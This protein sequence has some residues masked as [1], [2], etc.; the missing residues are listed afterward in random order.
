M[1][2]LVVYFSKFGNTKQ[3]A[4][5]I[6][7]TLQSADSVRVMSAEQLAT[8]GFAGADLVV[9]GTPTHK[10]NLPQTV[11]PV[12]YSLPKCILKDVPV[13]VHGLAAGVTMPMMTRAMQPATAGASSENSTGGGPMMMGVLTGHMV[14]GLVVALV[15]SALLQ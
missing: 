5:A 8:I 12:L 15:Y 11:R 3:V 9:M 4:E 7:E 10:M 2:T 1:N 13:A 14:F 6:A